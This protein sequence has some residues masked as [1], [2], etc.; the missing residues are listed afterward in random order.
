MRS[1]S[2]AVHALQ[3]QF[4]ALEDEEAS[5]FVAEGG[6]YSADTMAALQRDGVSWISRVP[7]TSTAAKAAID[8]DAPDWQEDAGGKRSWL[9]RSPTLEHGPK[10][11][12][13]VRTRAGEERA[14]ATMER[15][16]RKEQERW[17]TALWHLGN[18]TFA[19]AADAEA[20]LRRE[21]AALPAWCS[22]THTLREQTRYPGRGRPAAGA[23]GTPIWTVQATLTVHAER[24]AREVQRRACVIIGTNITDP[25]ML[26]DTDVIA[27]DLRQGSVERGFRFL[28][29][30]LFLASS[31]VVKKPA[32]IVALGVIMVLCV[33]VYRLAEGRLRQR[34]A[35]RGQTIPSQTGKPTASPTLRWVFGCFEGLDL[36][37]IRGPAQVQQ[38]V[39]GLRPVH[40]HVLA[41]LGPAYL[42]RYFPEENPE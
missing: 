36:L 27:T 14:R 1:L 19:C 40:Q 32:R 39:L 21:T 6:L 15:V 24:V 26:S 33:L 37:T 4:A 35:Q 34:L 31:V 10:R 29:D 8:L 13:I 28:K 2:V 7:D 18:R 25:T 23:V 17:T 12:L 38:R 9:V 42:A 30:P 22:V 41:L 11:W 5:I 16:V 3:A 20:A